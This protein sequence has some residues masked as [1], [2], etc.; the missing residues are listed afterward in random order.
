MKEFEQLEWRRRKRRRYTFK[1]C[2]TVL[3]CP[4]IKDSFSKSRPL[5]LDGY[6]KITI[7]LLD[8]TMIF[9]IDYIRIKGK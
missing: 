2:F 1:R 5:M 3:F 6:F 8:H 7:K 9:L 4:I